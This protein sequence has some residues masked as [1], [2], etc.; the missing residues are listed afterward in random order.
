[1]EEQVKQVHVRGLNLPRPWSRLQAQ[2]NEEYPPGHD[3]HYSD[4]RNLRR[5]FKEAFEALVGYW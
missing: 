1:M 4:Y 5:D 3:W 2:W